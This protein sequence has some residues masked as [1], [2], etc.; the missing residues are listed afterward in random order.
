MQCVR[1]RSIGVRLELA[2]E[3]D[4]DAG[5]RRS[6]LF[7]DAMLPIS[8]TAPSHDDQVAADRCERDARSSLAGPEQKATGCPEAQHRHDTQLPLARRYVAMPARAVALVAVEV[9]PESVVWHAV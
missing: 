3:V 2:L 1:V 7:G 6:C 8:L 5:G 9:Q 4:A